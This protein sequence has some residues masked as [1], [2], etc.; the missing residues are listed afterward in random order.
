MAPLTRLE[1]TLSKLGV[2][3]E[4]GGSYSSGCNSQGRAVSFCLYFPKGPF[5][6]MQFGALSSGQ[7]FNFTV[8]TLLRRRPR[9]RTQHA[10][11]HAR[12]CS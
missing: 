8:R 10:R 4:G 11:M 5:D 12:A 6:G 9:W 7:G 2:L 1:Q 3:P